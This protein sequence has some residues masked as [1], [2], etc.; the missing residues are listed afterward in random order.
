MALGA[1]GREWVRSVSAGR[2]RGGRGDVSS[3]A[4]G[5]R[6]KGVARAK[7]GQFVKQQWDV[8]E[9]EVGN[10]KEWDVER[11]GERRDRP[12][13]TGAGENGKTVSWGRAKVAES[14]LVF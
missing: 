14:S 8:L 7:K 5:S 9:S 3:V 10:W 2:R 4:D 13:Q 11:S 12:E 6:Q 1:G